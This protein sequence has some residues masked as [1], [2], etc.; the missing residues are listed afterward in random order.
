MFNMMSNIG[1]FAMSK[2]GHDKGEWYVIINEENDFYYLSDGRLKPVESPKK[3]NK[4]HV[5]IAY[6]NEAVDIAKNEAVK[7]SLK[8]FLKEN[9]D[10]G[11]RG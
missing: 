4:K 8:R 2:A 5:Q 3:K 9:L 7:F 10:D 11:K 6:N 1:N